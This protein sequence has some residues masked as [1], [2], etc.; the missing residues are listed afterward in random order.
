MRKY[1][2][3][4]EIVHD[5]LSAVSGGIKKTHIMY[6]AN[7][8]YKLLARYLDDLLTADLVVLK[9]NSLYCLTERGEQFLSRCK[10]Y[11]TLREQVESSIEEVND[12]GLTLKQ[13]LSKRT[14]IDS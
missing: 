8:S 1:R 12:E 6:K 2:D 9:E 14:K 7:L 4:L 5:I 11:F 3:K 10:I 13:M